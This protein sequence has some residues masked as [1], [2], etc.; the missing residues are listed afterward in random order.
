MK[1]ELKGQDLINEVDRL[2]TTGLNQGEACDKLGIRRQYFYGVKC[3]LKRKIGAPLKIVKRNKQVKVVD[4]LPV[5][6]PHRMAL[7]VGSPQ[8]LMTVVRGLQ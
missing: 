1:T 3:S 8:D 4:V 7:F 2:I 6:P 5:T